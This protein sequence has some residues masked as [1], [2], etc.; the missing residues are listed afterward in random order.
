MSC[1]VTGD[2][3]VMTNKGPRQIIDIEST[4]Q[5]SLIVNGEIHETNSEGF[6]KSGYTTT[7]LVKTSMGY[8]F[9]LSIAD[10]NN[11][12]VKVGGIVMLNHHKNLRWPG[13][14]KPIEDG[15]SVIEYTSSEFQKRFLQQHLGKER[16]I[17][18]SDRNLL[19]KIQRML[20]RFGA[21]SKIEGK[22]LTV[23]DTAT[24]YYD[25]V[26]CISMSFPRPVYTCSVP[27]AGCFDG[28]GIVIQAIHSEDSNKF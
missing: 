26:T 22:T 18:S 13:D 24:D 12:N 20:L 3:W 4:G 28:N 11:L 23:L 17:T 19:E 2:T 5:V 1:H 27:T 14:D 10:M 6:F 15:V 7:V 9:C 21:L 8:S 25:M 16:C